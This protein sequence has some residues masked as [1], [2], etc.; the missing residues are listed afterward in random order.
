MHGRRLAIT[1]ASACAVVVLFSLGVS[2]LL[3][4]LV[5]AEPVIAEPAPPRSKTPLRVPAAEIAASAVLTA[6]PAPEPRP[7][8]KPTPTPIVIAEATPPGEEPSLRAE[9]GMARSAALAAE[10]ADPFMVDDAGIR[11]MKPRCLDR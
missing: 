7:A 2:T 9:Q 10:C 3:S 4:T 6:A 11:Q 8:A 1:I 5:K